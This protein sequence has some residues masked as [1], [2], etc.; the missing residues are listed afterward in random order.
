[1][2]TFVDIPLQ[3][4]LKRWSKY[5]VGVVILGAVAVLIGWYYYIDYLKSPLPGSKEMNPAAAVAF[6][7]SGL[8]FLLITSNPFSRLKQI[9]GKLLALFVLLIGAGKLLFYVARINLHIDEV[10]FADKIGTD[11]IVA[12]A[13]VCFVL[14]GASLLMIDTK[15]KRN[16]MLSDTV[17]LIL[18]SF[19]VFSILGYFFQVNLFYG[20]FTYV[21]MAIHAAVCFLF[22]SLGIFLFKCDR[23]LM[24][25]LTTTLAGSV[26]ARR[27]IPAAILVPVLLGI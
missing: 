13:S 26:A 9:V 22:I 11:R 25:N 21:P 27:L 3:N 17:L 6:I 24:Q 1:M 10:L 2:R 20:M 23:G 7:L 4:K 14:A 12:I 15:G 16:D 8:S 18:T 5:I 19:S